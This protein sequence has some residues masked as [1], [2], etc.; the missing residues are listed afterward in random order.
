MKMRKVLV[1]VGIG[2]LLVLVASL[3]V[4]WANPLDKAV[5]RLLKDHELTRIN[6][7]APSDETGFSSNMYSFAP[8]KEISLK[9]MQQALTER[10]SG[11]SVQM[12]PDYIVVQ[13]TENFDDVRLQVEYST[14]PG[15]AN[16]KELGAL[17][18][19]TRYGPPR[20]TFWDW[21]GALF[22]Q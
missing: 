15:W 17:I 8:G 16:S 7:A 12:Y 14:D 2:A 1:Y 10:C 18:T 6:I 19:V 21:V 13:D 5:E 3:F 20:R 22:A 9:E 11:C 4:S